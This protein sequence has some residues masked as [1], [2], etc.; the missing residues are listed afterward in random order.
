MQQVE[1]VTSGAASAAAAVASKATYSGTTAAIAGYAISND[2]LSAGG[3]VVAILGFIVNLYF[4]AKQDRREDR[5]HQRLE[6]EHKATMKRLT[7]A[8]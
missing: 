3:F 7:Q 4:K 8:P 5:E 6:E 2:W 1:E